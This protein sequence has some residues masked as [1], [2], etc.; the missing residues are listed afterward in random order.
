M[1]QMLVR[2]NR[3]DRKYPET[4]TVGLSTASPTR[5]TRAIKEAGGSF[6]TSTGNWVLPDKE[7]LAKLQAK[8]HVRPCDFYLDYR[9]FSIIFRP[10]NSA[11][12]VANDFDESDMIM[13]EMQQAFSNGDEA[14]TEYL[15]ELKKR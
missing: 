7:A 12:Y 5:L 11:V 4:Y 10:T 15:A 14:F 1:S 9:D 2:V 6:D 8:F 3:E 13:Q